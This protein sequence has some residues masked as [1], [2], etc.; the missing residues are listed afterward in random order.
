MKML[1]CLIPLLGIASCQTEADKSSSKEPE[2]TPEAP[3]DPP[4]NI[5]KPESL[6]GKP[7]DKVKAACDSAEI[8]NRVIELDGE[9][10]PA[11]MDYRPE[12]LNFAVKDGIII[13]V[14]TG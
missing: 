10:L 8:P 9:G 4:I 6:V 7:L 1:L 2:P 5:S 14:T 12:R 3:A 11:T 13:R